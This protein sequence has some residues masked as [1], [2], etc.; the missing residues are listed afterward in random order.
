MGRTATRLAD[1]GT[2]I[3]AL[4]RLASRPGAAS[5]AALS[6]AK[7][8]RDAGAA[9]PSAERVCY[10]L[11]APSIQRL[12]GTLDPSEWVPKQLAAAYLGCSV[13]TVER[14]VPAQV[15]VAGPS[16]RTGPEDRRP[17]DYAASGLYRWGFVC[18]LP[19]TPLLAPAPRSGPP[20]RN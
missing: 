12:F 9:V 4:L 13:L 7:Q 6:D 15:D 3:D 1:T 10:L 16:C 11:N 19:R 14:R 2:A 17:P 5:P 8:A 20:A 18:T